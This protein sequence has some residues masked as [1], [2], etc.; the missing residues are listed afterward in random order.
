[1]LK[2][3][4]SRTN[5]SWGG[6]WNLNTSYVKV[7]WKMLGLGVGEGFEFKYILC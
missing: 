4:W 6:V 3:N 5:A 1:M 7:Q 2:F